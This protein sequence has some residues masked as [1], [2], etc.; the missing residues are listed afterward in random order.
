MGKN[1]ML[2]GLLAMGVVWGPAMGWAQSGNTRTS[3]YV[4]TATYTYGDAE[5]VGSSFG[6][7]WGV[8]LS[9]SLLFSISGTSHATEGNYQ[10]GNTSYPI[11][12]NTISGSTGMTHFLSTN[13]DAAIVPFY[14]AGF[15][16]TSYQIDFTYP[17]SGLGTTSGTAPG[18]FGSLGVEMRMGSNITF[19][20]QYRIN[21]HN[22]KTEAGDAAFLRSDGLLISLRI[23]S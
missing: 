14:E 7:G 4:G 22:I 8:S 21:A 9:D 1:F 18:A 12:A 15:S 17:G 13:R 11:S 3:I 2:F 20:P 5:T 16:V 10:D 23:R 6:L 19:I